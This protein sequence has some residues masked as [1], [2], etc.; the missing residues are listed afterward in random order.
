[1]TNFD[2]T[3]FTQTLKWTL[4]SSYKSM[5]AIAASITFA[6]IVP[7]A[8]AT[9]EGLNMHPGYAENSLRSAMLMCSGMFLIFV[10]IGG[11][12]IFDNMK[13][14]E[15]RITFKM[16]PASDLEK[17]AARALCVTVIWVAIGLAA[18]CAADI[19]RMLLMLVTGADRVYS[20]IP[21][22]MSLPL[23][24]INMPDDPT[25]TLGLSLTA[26]VIAFFSFCTWGHA[27]YVLGGT[28]FR[29][30]QFALTTVCHILLGFVVSTVL[31]LKIN[32]RTEDDAIQTV[33]I[34]TNTSAVVFPILTVLCWWLSYKIFKRMQ[35]INNKW[36]NI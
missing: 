20:L 19:T 27:S 30:R 28:L 33:K 21:E 14:K 24:K 36:I 4:R 26:T 12:W 7:L 25:N 11:C 29:R 1:M 5:L 34:L 18:F 6:Y 15:Q 23:L 16:L 22:F 2:I 10:S 8:V 31:S 9:L 32:I 17:F 3:R 13:T 35:V